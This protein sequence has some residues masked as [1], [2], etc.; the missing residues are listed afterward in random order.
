MKSEKQ[1]STACRL[2]VT[3][4]LLLF[5]LLFVICC[6]V[7]ACVF[8][9]ADAT[10][11]EAKVYNAAVSLCRSQAERLRSGEIPEDGETLYFDRQ[12]QTCEKEKGVYRVTF[13]TKM[14]EE[15]N[16]TMC[17]VTISAGK[18]GEKSAYRLESMVYRPQED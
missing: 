12:L 1:E 5:V 7:L 11:R 9:R 10:S 8:V 3:G 18:A 4:P 15:K 14:T 16:E 6:G 17:K 2:S 13:E